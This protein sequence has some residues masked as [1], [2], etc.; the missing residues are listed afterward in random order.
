MKIN[1]TT[2]SGA[3]APG[4]IQERSTSTNTVRS[5]AGIAGSK[6]DQ[7]QL[8]KLSS[9]LSTRQSSSPQRTSTLAELGAAVS[10]GRYHVDAHQVSQ[11]LIEEHLA[12]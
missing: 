7:L 12:A 6:P 3:S 5:P 9:Y 8:S 1:H 4:K 11:K 10:T 2:V